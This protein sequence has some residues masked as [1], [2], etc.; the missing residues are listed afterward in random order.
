MKSQI[1][2]GQGCP[3]CGDTLYVRKSPMT[4]VCKECGSALTVM[5]EGG[6]FFICKG[7][8]ITLNDAQ[9]QFSLSEEQASSVFT[10]DIVMIQREGQQNDDVI[11]TEGAF[12][13]QL[14]ATSRSGSRSEV[15]RL[16]NT[17]QHQASRVP[18]F[19]GSSN[20]RCA[21]CGSLFKRFKLFR[22]RSVVNGLGKNFQVH[23]RCLSRFARALERVG[24]KI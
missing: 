3:T 14:E 8:A 22:R 23:D 6:S 17:W 13:N 1:H 10:D 24:V 21:L 11:L 12:I 5:S 9:K 20:T 15:Q 4:F 19:A 18:E 7:H 16:V 2:E